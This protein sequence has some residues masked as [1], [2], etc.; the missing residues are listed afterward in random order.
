MVRTLLYIL[1]TDL[2]FVGV[3]C[4]LKKLLK[5]EFHL[6]LFVSKFHLISDHK[7]E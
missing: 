4:E 1:M 6:P 3:E 2:S 5:E 7:W